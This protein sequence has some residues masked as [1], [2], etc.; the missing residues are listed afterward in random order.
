[1]SNRPL[2]DQILADRG[3]TS[4]AKTAKTPAAPTVT[5]EDLRRAA[6]N[7]AAARRVAAAVEARRR[8][9]PKFTREDLARELTAAK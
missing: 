8:T 1:M 6:S 5:A 3:L 7:P 9:N 4:Q 2:R